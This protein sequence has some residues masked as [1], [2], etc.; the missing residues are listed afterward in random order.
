MSASSSTSYGWRAE[1]ATPNNHYALLRSIEARFGLPPLRHAV[2]P[3]TATIPALA[4]APTAHGASRS[5]A[6]LGG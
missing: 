6:S 3:G 4:V 2:D 5:P 1:A